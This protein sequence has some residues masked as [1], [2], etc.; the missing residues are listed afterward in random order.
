LEDVLNKSLREQDA[1]Q[2]ADGGTGGPSNLKLPANLIPTDRLPDP[3]IP[4]NLEL[5]V[6]RSEGGWVTAAWR[7]ALPT[8]GTYGS[9]G[10]RVVGP[11]DVPA[12]VDF[13]APPA[14]A[15]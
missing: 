1:K 13:V 11:V 7:H 9:L 3:T 15:Q 8:A 14:P 5:V 6:F 2:A 12:I 4:Q 10:A